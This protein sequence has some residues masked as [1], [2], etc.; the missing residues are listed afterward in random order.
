[1]R[2]MNREYRRSR[3]PSVRCRTDTRRDAN[4]HVRGYN[5]E[6]TTTTPFD[7]TVLNRLDRFHLVL[8]VI[9]RVDG[10]DPSSAPLAQLIRDKLIEHRHYIERHGEDMPEIRD[11]RWRARPRVRQRTDLGP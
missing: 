2:S 3:A 4:L 6:G 9:K 5:E 1:M 8:D 11:W 7:M 10:L